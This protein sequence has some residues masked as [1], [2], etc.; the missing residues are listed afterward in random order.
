MVDL[1]SG[2]FE[3]LNFYRTR[4]VVLNAGGFV[5]LDFLGGA[6]GRFIQIRTIAFKPFFNCG[7]FK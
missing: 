6:G 3:N 2:I 1:G 5:V 7:P 4:G